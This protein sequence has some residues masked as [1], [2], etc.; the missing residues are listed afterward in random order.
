MLYR[1]TPVVMTYLLSG[2]DLYVA[3]TMHFFLIVSFFVAQYCVHVYWKQKHFFLC[4][5]VPWPIDQYLLFVYCTY[6]LTSVAFTIVLGFSTS[7]VQT[8]QTSNFRLH[9]AQQMVLYLEHTV[10]QVSLQTL[11]AWRAQYIWILHQ[12]APL[13]SLG[14]G[15]STSVMHVSE[16]HSTPYTS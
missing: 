10:A 14:S 12:T 15:L 6:S 4:Q 2:Y 5:T 8:R 11:P 3:R 7:K 13:S 16:C 9:K 1:I